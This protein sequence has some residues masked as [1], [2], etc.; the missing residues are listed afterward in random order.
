MA[1]FPPKDEFSPLATTTVERDF[2]VD[3]CLKS[4]ESDQIAIPLVQELRQLLSKVGFRLTRWS[5]NSQNV[6]KSLPEVERAVSVKTLDFAS[7][8]VE[9]ALGVRWNVTSDT[10]GY[11]I[12]VKERPA[13]RRGILSIVSSIYDPLGFVSPFIFSAK[14]LLQDLCRSK[15]GWDDP[16]PKDALRR[17]KNWLAMLPKLKEFVI[18][19][20]L[21]P[22]S[23]GDVVSSQIHHF[24]D[25]SQQGYGA[26]SYLRIVNRNGDVHCCFLIGKSRLAPLKATTIPRLELSA[27][28]VATKLDKMMR[29]ELDISPD[30]S[31]FW[32]DSTCVLSYT[33]N[34]SRRSR[35]SLLTEYQRSMTPPNRPN[36]N[37]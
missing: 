7:S 15:L 2:Y 36:G 8:P 17:W 21:K 23:F 33:Q 5:S 9:R 27:A 3:D 29:Q 34:E 13:T 32:T 31:I 12:V 26:V 28:V 37:T 30:E 14:I 11:K 10:F 16:V 22:A 6:L 19:R 1:V 4:V 18:D 25:A 35:L 24:A 20:C